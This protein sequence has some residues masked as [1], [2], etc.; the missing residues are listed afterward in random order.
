MAEKITTPKPAKGPEA[1][2][3]R[4]KQIIANRDK[5][6]KG[7]VA[8]IKHW[9][10]KVDHLESRLE[11]LEKC[12][13]AL[14][15]QCREYERII[16]K[17]VAQLQSES[18]ALQASRRRTSVLD[19]HREIL[20]GG[21]AALQAEINRLG[22]EAEAKMNGCN[23]TLAEPLWR[24]SRKPSPAENMFAN[25]LS[26]EERDAGDDEDDISE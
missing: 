3:A 11:T 15:D 24:D 1:T 13:Y 20:I 5:D 8:T 14:R 26:E 12:A 10:T 19:A 2:I 25:W 21:M 17:Q 9:V 16:Q 4:L 18:K 7:K 23:Q 6:V 22:A